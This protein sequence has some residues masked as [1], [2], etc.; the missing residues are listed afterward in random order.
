MVK[1]EE[2]WLKKKRSCLLRSFAKRDGKEEQEKG[3][4]EGGRSLK[5]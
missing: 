1:V 3:S 2:L 5:S 4:G